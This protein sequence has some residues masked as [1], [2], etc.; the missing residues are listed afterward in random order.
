MDKNK[1]FDL[2]QSI[3]LRKR[4]GGVSAMWLHRHQDEL[5]VP[6]RIANRRF[7][8]L[9]EVENYI[10]KLTAARSLNRDV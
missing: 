9:S 2:I 5:P 4:L 3:G 8:V 7:W 6:V 10:Q 1:L